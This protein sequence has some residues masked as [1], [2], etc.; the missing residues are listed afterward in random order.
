MSIYFDLIDTKSLDEKI[1]SGVFPFTRNLFW[2]NSIENIDLKKNQR[3][4]I[5]RVLTRGFTADFYILL[6][7]YTAGEIK[8]ALRKSKELDP[9]TLQFCSEY[10]N[11][12]KSEMHVSSFY[13]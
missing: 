7:I 4:V 11:I 6:K 8:D 12:N 5:E 3:Y 9:K 13:R 2:D 1:K 10:F